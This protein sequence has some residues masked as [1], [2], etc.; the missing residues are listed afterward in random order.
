MEFFKSG[1]LVVLLSVFLAGQGC[2]TPPAKHVVLQTTDAAWSE[3][4]WSEAVEGLQCRLRPDRR[5]WRMGE[6]PSFKVDIRN[7]GKRIFAF[8]PF[9]QLQ[10]CRIQ[11]DD[12]RYQWPS[13]FMIDSPVWPLAPGS[14]FND[15][16]I[17]LHERFK[18]NLSPGRH[19]VRA[20]FSLEGI[21]VVSNPVGIEIL[22][23]RLPVERQQRG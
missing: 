14:Q 9:H 7:Q 10:L 8:L 11:F 15:I 2:K 6:R 5:T 18:I 23:P 3:P 13:P 16:A 12:K 22:P 21:E 4:V 1:L 17:T 20:V 19:I